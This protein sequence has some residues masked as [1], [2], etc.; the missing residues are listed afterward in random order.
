MVFVPMPKML[1][2]FTTHSITASLFQAANT[3]TCGKSRPLDSG[4]SHIY[5]NNIE[6]ITPATL[7]PCQGNVKIGDVSNIAITAKG[8]V[9]LQVYRNGSIETATLFS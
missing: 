8:D 1:D 4:A 5:A 7:K 6:A 9:D 3:E 2:V